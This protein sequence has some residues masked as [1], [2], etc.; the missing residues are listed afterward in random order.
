MKR[1]RG[2][3]SVA[4][5]LGW[6]G[7]LRAEL[8]VIA[9]AAHDPVWRDLLAQL[10][11]TK[12]RQSSFE[13]RRY[14]PFRAG[15][16]VLTGEIRTEPSHGL[17]LRYLTPDERVLIADE[18]GLLMRDAVGRERTPPADAR[19]QAA[20]TALVNVLR[21]DLPELQKT[22]T[23][24][25]R[26]DGEGW[27]LQ[28]VPADPALAAALGTLTLSGEALRLRKIELTRSASQRIEISVIETHENVIFTG[29][30]LKRFF[31]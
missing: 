10:A 23:L 5:L 26:R 21:F 1:S 9:D 28:F 31:R 30:T 2:L 7:P 4:L 16:V 11:P 3:F 14:F 18:K 8:P 25:G 17:S 27:T 19:A 6:L 22:F 15:A 24:R 13:E 29:E 12:A 20:M